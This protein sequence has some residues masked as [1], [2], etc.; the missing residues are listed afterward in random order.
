MFFPWAESCLVSEK[1]G[2]ERQPPALLS[3]VWEVRPPAAAGVKVGSG[4]VKRREGR[5]IQTGRSLRP[6]ALSTFVS[7]VPIQSLA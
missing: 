6:E 7:L 5:Q 2:A 3:L 4:A 1:P